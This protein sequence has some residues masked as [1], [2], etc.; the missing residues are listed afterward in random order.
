M[1]RPTAV[2]NAGP[3]T[4]DSRADGAMVVSP[5]WPQFP[6]WTP[7]DGGGPGVTSRVFLASEL[8]RWLNDGVKA[9]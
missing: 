2:K 6:K 9:E 7:E 4:V 1:R 3:Y 5:A 8:E